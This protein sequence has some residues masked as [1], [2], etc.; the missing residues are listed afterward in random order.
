MM[1]GLRESGIADHQP[2]VPEKPTVTIRSQ[3]RGRLEERLSDHIAVPFCSLAHEAGHGEVRYPAFRLLF[4]QRAN[5]GGS[6]RASSA[7]AHLRMVHPAPEV[8]FCCNPGR[9]AA[10]PGASNDGIGQI[11]DRRALSWPVDILEMVDCCERDVSRRVTLDVPI[12]RG[13]K[14]P[15]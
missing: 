15:S 4:S 10:R 2:V 11:Q 5:G 3:N 9:A 14:V 12:R 7:S 1:C 8:A 6:I 13:R